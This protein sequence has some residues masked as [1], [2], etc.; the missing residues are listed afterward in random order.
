[1]NS[2]KLPN[3][4]GDYSYMQLILLLMSW[5]VATDYMD[6]IAFECGWWNK[7]FESN[8]L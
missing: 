8:E 6:L 2:L 4:S 3:L 1:M 5:L 7:W